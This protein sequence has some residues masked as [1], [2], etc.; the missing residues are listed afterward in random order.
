MVASFFDFYKKIL[1]STLA[2]NSKKA[3]IIKV[4]S[5]RRTSSIPVDRTKIGYLC[6]MSV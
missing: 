5:Y 2:F 3:L 4:F 1:V 6:E